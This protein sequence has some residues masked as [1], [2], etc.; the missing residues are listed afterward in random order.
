VTLKVKYADFK[1]V[2]KRRTLSRPVEDFYTFW[3]M[4]QDLLSAVE[5]GQQKKI[6]LMGLYIS[7]A[8]ETSE[9]EDRQ[10][11]LDFGEDEA[12]EV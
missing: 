9:I 12:E 10:L 6:R 8:R 5:F 3:T 2:S 1:E 11:K 4:G 7:N